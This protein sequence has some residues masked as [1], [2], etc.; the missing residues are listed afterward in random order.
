MQT[1][2]CRIEAPLKISETSQKKRMKFKLNHSDDK[3]DEGLWRTPRIL[4]GR[5][6]E[7]CIEDA[8]ITGHSLPMT[9]IGRVNKPRQTAYMPQTKTKSKIINSS[10]PKR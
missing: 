4:T 9:P 5:A 8:T 2:C 3:K 1:D 7:N 10:S 6:R